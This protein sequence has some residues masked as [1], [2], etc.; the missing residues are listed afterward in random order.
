MKLTNLQLNVLVKALFD[1]IDK[2]AQEIFNKPSSYNKIS[3]KIKKEMK[4]DKSILFA[5]ENQSIQ[6]QINV[7]NNSRNELNKRYA[8]EVLGL[9]SYNYSSIPSISSLENTLKNKI[10]DEIYKEFPTKTELESDVILLTISG[11]GKE[12]L[13]K[14]TKKYKL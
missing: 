5:E 2:K 8:K 12:I 14:L 4:Y 6:E 1:K 10:K 13:E 9:N 3:N 11:D 7:L